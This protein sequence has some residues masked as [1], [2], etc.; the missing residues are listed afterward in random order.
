MSEPGGQDKPIR[1]DRFDDIPQTREEA[2]ATQETALSLLRDY[3]RG[4]P[5]VLRL[6]QWHGTTY[7]LRP[8]FSNN[9]TYKSIYG[10]RVVT[11]DIIEISFGAVRGSSRAEHDPKEEGFRFQRPAP[12]YRGEKDVETEHYLLSS[13]GDL[14]TTPARNRV[15]R[16]P[17]SVKGSQAILNFARSFTPKA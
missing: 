9:P 3:Y 2:L 14:V 12:I 8:S 6:L 17:G 11:P 4:V 15:L 5:E 1:K 16:V 7:E 10:S 13:E